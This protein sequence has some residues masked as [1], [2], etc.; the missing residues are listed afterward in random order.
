MALD[1]TGY[2]GKPGI[3]LQ[4]GN[5]AKLVCL[6]PTSGNYTIKKNLLVHDLH[7]VLNIAFVD[8]V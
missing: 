3:D 2:C 8:N 4:N 5:A 1:I 7:V 6:G